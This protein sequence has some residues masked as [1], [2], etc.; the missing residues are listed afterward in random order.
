VG[1]LRFST[2]S[3]NQ[4]TPRQSCGTRQRAF[5]AVRK[6]SLPQVKAVWGCAPMGNK[7]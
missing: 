4:Q 3:K 7:R 6:Q 1:C 2:S 5:F